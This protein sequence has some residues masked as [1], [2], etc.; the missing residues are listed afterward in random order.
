MGIYRNETQVSLTNHELFLS[1]NHAARHYLALGYQPVAFRYGTKG[2][3]AKG[4]NEVRMVAEEVD[5]FFPPDQ[6]MNIGLLTGEPSGNLVDVDLDAPEAVLVAPFLLPPTGMVHGREGKPA[7]HWW[8]KVEQNQRSK[9]F[10]DG[11]PKPIRTAMLVELR[12]SGVQTAVPP[13]IHPS[14]EPIVWYKGDSP[15]EVRYEELLH[16][17]QLVAAAALLAR[18][19]PAQGCRQDAALALSGGLLRG[20]LSE[21]EAEEFIEA[22]ATA[23]GDEEAGM[24]IK[25]VASTAQKLAGGEAV[26]GWP[27]LAELVGEKVVQ[28]VR[29]WLGVG[30]DP[31]GVSRA[32]AGRVPPAEE[33]GNTFGHGRKSNAEK[34][35]AAAQENGELF[36]TPEEVAYVRRTDDLRGET[37][38]VQSPACKLWLVGLGRRL[39]IVPGSKALADATLAL[40]AAA[41]QNKAVRQVYLRFARVAD[42]LFVDLADEQGQVVKVTAEGWQVVTNCPVAFLRPPNLAPLPVPKP[43]GCLQDLRKFLNV[44][45]EEFPL[46]RGFIL[47]CFKAVGP[48][49]VLL[50][51]GEQGSAKSTATKIL[52]QVIDPVHKALARRLQRDEY[53]LAI[54]AQKNAVLFF[55]NVSSLP[56]WLSD[57]IASLATGS[58]FAVRTLYSQDEETVYGNAVPICFNGIPDF[59]ESSDLL[60]RAIRVTL[61]RIADD[62]RL[63]EDEFEP[64]FQAARPRI[65]GAVLDAVSAGL[66]NYDNVKLKSLPRMARSARWIAACETCLPEGRGSFAKAYEKNREELIALAIENSP[67]ATA[68]L[69]WMDQKVVV[70]DKKNSERMVEPGKPWEGS[71]TAL[72]DELLSVVNGLVATGGGFPK[73]PNKLSGELRRVA[74]ALARAGVQVT[75]DRSNK[76]RKITVERVGDGGAQRPATEPAGDGHPV[77]Q[78]G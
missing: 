24:R 66:R 35:L 55:D 1:P 72:H 13:S 22:V 60:D 37:F 67:V 14:G 2:P 34:L 74:P 20:G 7:S 42:T 16:G 26:K 11:N 23:A 77:R 27:S 69:A 21:E 43:G 38:K 46:V 61:P 50:I 36:T 39:G 19:W 45:E 6:Q 65:L 70:G 57:A 32:K 33:K 41:F 56:Q 18:Y 59:A 64:A 8:Y 10:K 53:E 63:S 71:A 3:T 54:A 73:A 52:R 44:T 40:E 48:Y 76:A 78:A 49:M 15:A 30:S 31:V 28:Q 9:Q 62:K 58:G 4:W 29:G 51:N 47:D 25:A 68:L 5:H 75:L 17:V 12:G